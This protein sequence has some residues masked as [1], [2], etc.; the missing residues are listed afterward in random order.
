MRR[1]RPPVG[2]STDVMLVTAHL[3]AALAIGL[4]VLT[5]VGGEDRWS[6]PGYKTALMFPGAPESWGVAILTFGVMLLAGMLL[7]WPALVAAASLLCGMWCIF[8]AVTFT[9]EAQ[10]NHQVGLIGAWTFSVV[11]VLYLVRFVM[12]WRRFQ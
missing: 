7:K 5:I 10:A 2:I 3:Y 8:F 11:G 6:A 1:G 9:I 4:G 12:H